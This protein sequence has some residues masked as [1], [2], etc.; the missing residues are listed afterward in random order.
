MILMKRT[1]VIGAAMTVGV[2]TAG[3]ADEMKM[4][5]AA[6]IRDVFSGST[7]TGRFGKKNTRFAQ[8]N[9]ANG[10]A[11][12]HVDGSTVRLIPWLVQGPKSY[13]EDWA[14]N[15]V[16]CY[17][18]GHDADADKYVLIYADGSRIDINV[19]DGF[20]PITFD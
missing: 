20:H 6:E 3:Y 17:Q 7:I 15:G 4:L 8:R 2:I 10:I 14:E 12:V 11:V 18:I 19:Q 5:S 16:S 9:H 1:L 13:C